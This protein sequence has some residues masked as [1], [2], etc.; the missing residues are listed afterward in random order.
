[1]NMEVHYGFILL[2]IEIKFPERKALTL[3]IFA[4]FVNIKK[5][6][7]KFFLLLWRTGIDLNCFS[8]IGY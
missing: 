7:K 5:V 2:E 8:D 3:W 1:M 6:T 4:P